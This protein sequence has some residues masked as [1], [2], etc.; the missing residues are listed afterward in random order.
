MILK[1][2]DILSPEITLFYNGSLSHSSRISGILTIIACAIIVLCASYYFKDI[3]NRKNEIPKVFSYNLFIEDAGVFP[4]NSS[5]FF[6]FISANKDDKYQG[7]EFDFTIFN[8]IGFDKNLIDYE[9]NNDLTK[10]N[11]WLYGF[12]SYEI[13]TIGIEELVTQ[14][15]FERPVCIK[16]YFNAS[17]QKYYKIGDPNFRRPIMAHGTINLNKEY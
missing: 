12:C 3:L 5:S 14:E 6:H 9:T 16:K 8:I 10:Y 13:D 15:Y 2:I 7:E 17:T 1:E 11:H 4:I